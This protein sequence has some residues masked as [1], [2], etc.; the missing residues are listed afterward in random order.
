MKTMLT[1]AL[2]SICSS[3]SPASPR[4]LSLQVPPPVAGSFSPFLSLMSESFHL[5]KSL[6]CPVSP[7]SLH[8]CQGPFHMS[9]HFNDIWCWD[10][11]R[12]AQTQHHPQNAWEGPGRQLG[13][14][15]APGE[16]ELGESWSSTVLSSSL[17]SPPVS[18]PQEKE[19]FEGFSV[20]KS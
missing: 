12:E 18:Y 15:E 16:G 6:L 7:V 19:L 10:S 2:L 11:R 8:L 14:K 4:V 5:T 20:K 9:E 13:E 1:A 17:T 3:C